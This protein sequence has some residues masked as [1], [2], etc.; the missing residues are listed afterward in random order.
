MTKKAIRWPVGGHPVVDGISLR[1]AGA[2]WYGHTY[3][4]GQQAPGGVTLARGIPR[5]QLSAQ[6]QAV[7]AACERGEARR[8]TDFA[9]NPGNGD[10]LE[11]V[12]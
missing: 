2:I 7:I 6:A 1:Q 12:I 5:E 3:Q 10:A 8:V 4:G 9:C 11:V